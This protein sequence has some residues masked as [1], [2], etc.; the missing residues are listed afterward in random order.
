[1]GFEGC[2]V[3]NQWNNFLPPEEFKR[4]PNAGEP[5]SFFQ[6]T[7][8]WNATGAVGNK[9]R[10][11]VLRYNMKDWNNLYLQFSVSI[12]HNPDRSGSTW[13]VKGLLSS[14]APANAT[15]LQRLSESRVTPAWV[16]PPAMDR[17]IPSDPAPQGLCERGQVGG[18]VE[19]QY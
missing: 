13:K 6:K 18:V 10:D 4:V 19:S 15:R 8:H 7:P 11:I 9:I 1:M 2:R 17:S 14:L 16:N 12:Q 5:L 3:G